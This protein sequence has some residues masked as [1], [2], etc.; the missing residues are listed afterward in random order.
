[1]SDLEKLDGDVGEL[2]RDAEALHS[3]YQ[4]AETAALG[5][6]AAAVRRKHDAT[7]QKA[8]KVREAVN[9]LLNCCVRN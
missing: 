4:S 9:V 8:S 5:K 3:E 1:M 6:G 7:L 2:E